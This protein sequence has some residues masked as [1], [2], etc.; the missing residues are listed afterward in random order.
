MA[1]TPAKDLRQKPDKSKAQPEYEVV[2]GEQEFTRDDELCHERELQHSLAK[3][4]IDTDKAFEGQSDRV[5]DILDN[6]DVYNCVLGNK[7]FYTGNSQLYLPLVHNAVNARK[8]RFVNQ[9][10][11]TSQ[12]NV[13]AITEDGDSPSSTIALMEH[14][15]RKNRLRSAVS[16][17]VKNGDI[18]GQYTLYAHWR[19]NK[20][21]V[22]YKAPRPIEIQIAENMMVEDPDDTVIDIVEQEVTH[23]YPT[24]EVISDT[25]FV[26]FPATVDSMEEALD[27]GG[28]VAV[29]RRYSKSR[30]EQMIEDGELDA[31]ASKL[32]LDEMGDKANE[33]A[34]RD[35]AKQ[36][37]DSAGV[38]RDARGTYAIVYE[39]FA[40]FAYKGEKRIYR[41][42]LAGPDKFL[43]CKR[44]PMW[45]DKL[46]IISAPVEKVPGFFKGRPRLS[47]GVVDLQIMANDAVNQGMDSAA[48]AL[49]PIVLTD[50]E[51]NPRVGSMIMAQAAIWETNPND[52]QFAQFP[53]L[54]RDAF[55]IIA[56]AKSEIF[57]TLSVNPAAITQALG[58][59]KP[60]QAE[61]AQEQQVD[62]L[63]TA[64][65]VTT[66]EEGVLT[67]LLHR[68]LEL[69]HQ[70]R[71]DA[72]TIRQYGDL[73]VEVSM[74]RVEP[75]QFHRR[76]E[77]RWFGVEAA[78]TAAQ[79]Q[80]Q[81]AATNVLRGIPPQF[82]QGYELS[83]VPIIKQLVENTFGPR[84]APLV[85]RDMRK[86][87]SKSPIIENIE[88]M[89]G[90][91]VQPSPM[92]N[93]QEHIQSHMRA[94]QELGDPHRT[95]E[96]HLMQH[97][98]LLMQ[99]MMQKQQQQIGSPGAPGG[100]GPGLPGQGGQPRGPNAGA[101][102][103]NGAIHPDQ[104]A[105]AGS[106][107]M[108]RNMG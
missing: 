46:P 76:W 98:A 25:N 22:V 72:L 99:Q 17:L 82:Y 45:S 49:M 8:T 101:Q 36:Q 62:L 54:W 106:P 2:S 83:L 74:E 100:A 50:P 73:G 103:P 13:E 34:K 5:N 35:V 18:E 21:N 78:R 29:L 53:P 33:S 93:H 58:K 20:R 23:S 12:R 65:A 47:A 104:M 24:V 85:F 107:I 59:K 80:Q 68:W 64:D 15:I 57:Q 1:Q 19:K 81:I 41:C 77:L 6:W 42:F 37:A 90:E 31:K 7:Q 43:S 75:I 95:F 96:V 26:V 61:I 108:P 28:G 14:Y 69:D 9:I 48:Y 105:G 91:F 84:L 51:K 70:H 11:P 88:L 66:I 32:L 40:K 94:M 39:V 71:D 56:A 79:V 92:D 44:N 89:Q 86:Q 87:L 67:P 63:T 3:L 4:Y 97:Q 30:I 10:F 52:T 60:N 16:A 55:E 27:S 102:Q 38:R